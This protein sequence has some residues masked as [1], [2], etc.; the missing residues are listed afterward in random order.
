MKDPEDV[1]DA[2]GIFWMVLFCKGY[3]GMYDPQ[4]GPIEG[5]LVALAKTIC[6]NFHTTRMRQVMRHPMMDTQ[7]QETLSVRETR[8]RMGDGVESVEFAML[9][10]RASGAVSTSGD[11]SM[12]GRVW[13]ALLAGDTRQEIMEKYG[14][15][16]SYVCVLV[17]QLRALPEVAELRE[18]QYDEVENRIGT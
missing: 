17:G 1:G 7:V 11:N 3:M 14:V 9:V 4:K 2:Q 6:R 15:S 16:K 13:N 5:F 8:D 18:G 10:E 12:R